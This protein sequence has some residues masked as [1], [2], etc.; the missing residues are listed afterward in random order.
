MI[1]RLQEC[2]QL[3]PLK[4][5]RVALIDIILSTFLS[6]QKHHEDEVNRVSSNQDL[7]FRLDIQTY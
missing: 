2:I 3:R 1:E 7:N 5:L 4:V 6:R